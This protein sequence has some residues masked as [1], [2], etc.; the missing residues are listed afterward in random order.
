MK[1]IATSIIR[2]D[3]IRFGSIYKSIRRT[4]SERNPVHIFVFPLHVKGLGWSFSYIDELVLVLG[5]FLALSTF[6][7][8]GIHMVKQ[9]NKRK[10]RAVKTYLRVLVNRC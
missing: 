1:S 4:L 8:S 3:D 7:C 10:I 6:S 9:M 5:L 2:D